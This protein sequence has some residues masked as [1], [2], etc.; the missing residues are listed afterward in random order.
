MAEFKGDYR[1]EKAA[2]T[3][4][5][6]GQAFQ[7]WLQSEVSR[8]IETLAATFSVPLS[9]DPL[10]PPAIKRQDTVQVLIGGVQVMSG[11]VI[12]AAPFYR[13]NDVGMRIIG[14]DRPGDLVRCAAMHAGGQWRN[15]GLE[16]ITK[17][18]IKPF[19]LDLVVEADL[20]GPI[21]DFKIYHGETVLDVLSRAARL[22]GVLAT[23]DDL[24]RVVLTKAGKSRFDGAIVRGLNVISMEDIGSDEQRFSE[25]LAYGQSTL[26]DDFETTRQIKASAKDAEMTRYMPTIINADGNTTQAEMQALVDHTVRV[27]RGHAYGFNYVV[28]GWTWKG[29]PWPLNARVPVFDDVAGLRGDD[30]LICSVKQTCSLQYGDVTELVVRPIEAYDTVPLKTKVKRHHRGDRKLSDR[31]HLDGGGVTIQSGSSIFKE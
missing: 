25:V 15:V 13:G 10:N 1:R 2:I 24:G 30:W 17:D 8:N 31:K 14:R 16:R 23:R 3:V 9:L 6:N 22:R 7:G 5:V 26:S 4:V 28:E 12:A 18:L 11:Y 19:G 27:R 29:K 20:G 21:A